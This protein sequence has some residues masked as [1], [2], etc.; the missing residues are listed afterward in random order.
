MDMKSRETIARESGAEKLTRVGRNVNILGAVA[1]GGLA[2]VVPGPNVLLA[3]WAGVNAAQAGGFELA[4]QHAKK[5]KKKKT[6]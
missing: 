1:I 5:R 2:L 3:A 4:R 6:K